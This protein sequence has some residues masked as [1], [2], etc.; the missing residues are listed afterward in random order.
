M[1][2]MRALPFAAGRLAIFLVCH[3]EPA[4]HSLPMPTGDARELGR[5]PGLEA[6][7]WGVPQNL[8]SPRRYSSGA[9]SA[10]ASGL[11]APPTSMITCHWPSIFF[12]MVTY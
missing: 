10:A 1:S 9:S 6:R 4:V 12:Q 5:V 11:R 8:R 3:L 2:S 7:G